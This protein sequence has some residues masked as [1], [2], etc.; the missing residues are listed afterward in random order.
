MS[1][2]FKNFKALPPG[3]YTDPDITVNL[4]TAEIVSN[5]VYS[6]GN[7]LQGTNTVNSNARMEFSV[8]SFRHNNNVAVEI[9]IARGIGTSQETHVDL[10]SD[11]SLGFN[12]RASTDLTA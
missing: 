9:E 3:V 7:A 6:E 11:S 5:A 2:F 12:S 10:F 1:Q 4:A 8:D